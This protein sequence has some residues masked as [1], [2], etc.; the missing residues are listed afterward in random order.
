MHTLYSL[1]RWRCYVWLPNYIKQRFFIRDE[2]GTKE[3]DRVHVIVAVVD[4]FEPSRREGEIGVRRVREWC[5]RYYKLAR[6]HLDSDGVLPQHS[7]FYRFD[8]PNFDCIK[9]LSEYVYK[10]L[11]EI[12]FHLHHGYDTSKS[13]AAKMCEGGSWFNRAGAMISAESEPQI[14]FGYIAGNWALDNGEGDAALSGVNDELSILRKMGCYADFT[15]PALGA[16]AQPKKVNSIYYAKDTPL[17]KSYN[18][19][20]DVEV[21]KAAC[22]DLMIF[23]GP[24]YVDWKKGFIE[25]AALESSIP[26]FPGRIHY[27][28]RAGVH[29][30]GRENW[31]FIKLHTH[32][33]QSMDTLLSYQ[34]GEVF[35]DLERTFKK[36][37]YCLHYVTAREAFN[38]VKAAEAGKTGDPNDYRDFLISP[39]ANRKIFC[40]QPY[41]LIKYSS[42][43]VIV[44]LESGSNNTEMI[45]KD[46]PLKSIKGKGLERIDLT[47]GTDASRRLR[48]EGNGKC[49]LSYK[50]GKKDACRDMVEEFA[51]PFTLSLG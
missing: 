26:Y 10:D 14:R 5:E 20:V 48:V 24:L 6:G 49:I 50:E 7:W 43:H 44:D 41:K 11:G 3:V 37:P 1:L 28:V 18:G 22:G 2:K 40:N 17:P 47:Y 23:E 19:G 30:L 46:L 4:H 38:I 8:Y 35:S 45:F 33:M 34:L 39:P 31:I 25:S 12:E 51:V 9:I 29:V 16:R 36:S 13:Y 32:G 27:W 42:D 21:G 15:F